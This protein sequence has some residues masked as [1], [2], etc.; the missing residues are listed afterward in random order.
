MEVYI[1]SFL[2]HFQ[3]SVGSVLAGGGSPLMKRAVTLIDR[4]QSHCVLLLYSQV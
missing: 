2:K 1:V 4:S 3:E